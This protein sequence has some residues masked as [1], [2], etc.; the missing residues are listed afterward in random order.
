MS[1]LLTL[2]QAN[3]VMD[4][5]ITIL[6]GEDLSFKACD[7]MYSATFRSEPFP[8]NDLIFDCE[9]DRQ[10]CIVKI[11]TDLLIKLYNIDTNCEFEFDY[12]YDQAEDQFKREY[13]DFVINDETL[14]IYPCN[15]K[16]EREEP[17]LYIVNKEL[18]VFINK[19]ES[20]NQANTP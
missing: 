11:E 3:K 2:D 14:L 15:Y 12:L 20:F 8:L 17:E 5:A 4:Q 19:R 16:G 9:E 18:P 6:G 7:R 13:P 10:S 1:T